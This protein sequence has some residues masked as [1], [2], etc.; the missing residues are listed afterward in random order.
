MINPQSS[1]SIIPLTDEKVNSSDEEEDY[2]LS[3]QNRRDSMINE[4]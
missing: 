4:G 1:R 2:T 3:P